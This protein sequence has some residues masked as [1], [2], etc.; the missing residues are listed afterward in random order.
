MTPV[1]QCDRPCECGCGNDL[2]KSPS[3]FFKWSICQ[4]LW[5]LSQHYPDPVMWRERERENIIFASMAPYWHPG[6]IIDDL[7]CWPRIVQNQYAWAV[8]ADQ[9]SL[10]HREAPRDYLPSPEEAMPYLIQDWFEQWRRWSMD[11]SLLLAIYQP[12]FLRPV[13]V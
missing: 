10:P 9:N 4:Q 2:G 1:A 12:R 5:M 3:M 6:T 13:K 7:T 11:G 8:W